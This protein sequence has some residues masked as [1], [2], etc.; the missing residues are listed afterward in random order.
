MWKMSVCLITLRYAVLHLNLWLLLKRKSSY[1]LRCM[2]FFR[3]LNLCLSL[4]G[5]QSLLGFLNQRYLKKF[6]KKIYMYWNEIHKAFFIK[7]LSTSCFLVTFD[8]TIHMRYI[9]SQFDVIWGS[10][11]KIICLQYRHHF[12]V[13]PPNKEIRILYSWTIK[14][15]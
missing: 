13:S 8:V 10:L 5:L 9:S 11:G 6:W 1:N 2:A 12:F 4:L 14:V 3:C 15:E 7:S